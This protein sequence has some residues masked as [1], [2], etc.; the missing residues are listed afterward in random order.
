MGCRVIMVNRKE[1]Q[2]EEAIKAIKDEVGEKAQIEWKQCD[3]GNLGMV[4]QVFTEIA[5]SLDRLDL[6]CCL[7]QRWICTRDLQLE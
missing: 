2:G 7:L 6:V 3:L 5:Q 4:K 1:D